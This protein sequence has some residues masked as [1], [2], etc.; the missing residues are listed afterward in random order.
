MNLGAFLYWKKSLP[1][2]SNCNYRIVGS[3]SDSM[4]AQRN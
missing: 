3:K 2:E 1:E 4:E